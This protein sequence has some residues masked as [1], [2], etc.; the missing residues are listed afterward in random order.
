MKKI[1]P[2]FLKNKYAIV[3]IVVVFIVVSI[4]LYRKFNTKSAFDTVE[5]RIGNVV[6]TVG[7]TGTISPNSKADLAF[8][9][10]G[11][12]ARVYVKV[13]D[14][15]KRGQLIAAISNA[16]DRASLASAEATLSDMSRTLTP[17]EAA[18][19]KSALVSAEENLDTARQSVLDAVHEAYVKAEGALF[20]HTDTFFNNA[21]TLDPKITIRT[22][23]DTEEYNINVKRFGVT[24]ALTRWSSDVAAAQQGGARDILNK[25]RAYL[26]TIKD[27]MNSLSLIVG[28]IS[29]NNTG[30]S[31]ST[32]SGY[33]ETMNAGLSALSS[34]I[35]TIASAESSLSTAENALKQ[36]QS[37]Y[38]LKFAGNSSE[39]IAAQSAKVSAARA[40]VNQGLII[41]P[42]DGIVTKADPTE[43]EFVSAGQTGFA[44]QN[45]NFKIE[46]NVPEADI[47]KIKVGDNA[48]STLDAYGA[49]VNFPA[50]VILINPAETVIEGVPT[51]KVTLE[52]INPDARIRSGMTANLTILTH[53]VKDTLL[54]PSRAVI[55]TD[56][57]KSV[58]LLNSD[59]KTF[60]SV[61]VQT[62]L[63]GSDGNM[64]ILSGISVGDKVVTYVRQ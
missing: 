46:A 42:I 54:I 52:F 22:E 39:S 23:S 7:V 47:A 28:S 27:F 11:V 30:L 9:K 45:D 61:P 38:N 56:G 63:K 14:K 60:A 57:V 3:G 55:D 5:A 64:Q 20:N 41:S 19:Q 10:G 51:Y 62:G 48:E 4:F 35:S 8:E 21:Q 17:E 43:G 6:E 1:L 37:S 58:R 15:V 12:L 33:G 50:R 40:L 34:A 26:S 36:A 31:Q 24:T 18:V 29:T 32:I 59:G 53:E 25:S 44:V 16:G 13:G 49:D 2:K